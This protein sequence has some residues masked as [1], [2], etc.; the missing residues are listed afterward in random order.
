MII[1]G[2]ISCKS[3]LQNNKRKVNKIYILSSKKTKDFNY[4]RKLT[5]SKSVELIETNEDELKSLTANTKHGGIL[6]DVEI[7]KEDEFVDGDIFYFD[8]IE[9]PFNL[10]YMMRTAY[11]FG[12]QNVILSKRDYS[13]MEGQLLKS[14][15]GAYD[16]LN[17][18]YLDLENHIDEYKDYTIYALS[19]GE[20]SKDIFETKFSSKSLFMIG[21][22]KRGISS[23]L[24]DKANEYLYIPYGNEFRNSLNA[25]SALDVVSTLLFAQRKKQ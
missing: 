15:A 13:N 5:K 4:I 6:A 10:G 8:G 18:K 12:I 25:A 7:R 20:N 19:R 14:S 23:K 9:D 24:L 22:E 2:A 11:A 1:E 17:I 21:G 16:M 3:A